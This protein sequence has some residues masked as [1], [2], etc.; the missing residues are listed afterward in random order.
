MRKPIQ[1]FYDIDVYGHFNE[2]ISDKED[3]SICGGG[4]QIDTESTLH[5][6]CDDGTVWYLYED[7]WI[8][9]ELPEIPQDDIIKE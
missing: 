9:W 6:L 5:C 8:I 4:G 7:L 1:Y 3:D 2:V